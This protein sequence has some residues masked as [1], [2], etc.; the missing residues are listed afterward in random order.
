MPED[1]HRILSPMLTPVFAQIHRDIWQ[2]STILKELPFLLGEVAW[3]SVG[4]PIKYSPF[5]FF[6]IS[7][8]PETN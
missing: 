1:I 3:A 6:V 7:V 8:Q 4:M 2:N 5:S